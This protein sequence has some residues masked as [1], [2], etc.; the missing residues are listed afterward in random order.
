MP[1]IIEQR[2]Q[3]EKDQN[4]GETG[5]WRSVSGVSRSWLLP[6]STDVY[7][8]SSAE[9]YKPGAA[10]AFTDQIPVFLFFISLVRI[11]YSVFCSMHARCQLNSETKEKRVKQN[12][13]KGAF[14]KE[15]L[16]IELSQ[17]LI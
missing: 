14:L 17:E 12:Q 8:C 9:D 1:Y 11:V 10:A 4:K 7:S 6:K 2:K 15:L 5:A 13:V 3:K 16:H